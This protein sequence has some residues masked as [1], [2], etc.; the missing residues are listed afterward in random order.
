MQDDQVEKLS[1]RRVKF[2]NNMNVKKESKDAFAHHGK[3]AI[4]EASTARYIVAYQREFHF[5]FL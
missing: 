3:A 5:Y 2:R 4:I 1:V